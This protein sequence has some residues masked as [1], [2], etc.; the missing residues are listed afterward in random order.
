[1]GLRSEQCNL[2]IA[3][4]SNNTFQ[5]LS[6][7]QDEKIY[8]MDWGVYVVLFGRE[9]NKKSMLKSSKTLLPSACS[10]QDGPL[11]LQERSR[12]AVV[13]ATRPIW[14]P[15][16]DCAVVFGAVAV[17]QADIQ[18]ESVPISALPFLDV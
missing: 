7:D 2:T 6:R 8:R 3:L 12:I 15:P 11:T 16:D 5:G 17:D 1:M 14:L 18:P 9:F 4:R 13:R 10:R